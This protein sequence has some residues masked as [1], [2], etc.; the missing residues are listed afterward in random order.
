M[1][2]HTHD[3]LGNEAIVGV[4]QGVKK[5]KEEA[6]MKGDKIQRK[7]NMEPQVTWKTYTFQEPPET[8][9]RK[10]GAPTFMG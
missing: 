6:P 7:R 2:S 3:T 8:L 4:P 1:H 9:R 5:Q 10:L